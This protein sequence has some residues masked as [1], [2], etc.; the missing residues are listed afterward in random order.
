MVEKCEICNR[1]RRAWEGDDLDEHLVRQHADHGPSVSIQYPERYERLFENGNVATGD[2]E[3]GGGADAAG[4][5]GD[6][7]VAE[8]GTADDGDSGATTSDVGGGG[9]GPPAGGTDRADGPAEGGLDAPTSEGKKWYVIGVGGAG[10]NI[11][12]AILCRRETLLARNDDRA[13]LWQGGLAGYGLLNTN[14]V[15]LERTYYVQEE[16]GWERGADI[17]ENAMIGRGKHNYQGMGRRWDDGREVMQADFEEG[18]PFRTRWD[19]DVRNIRDA[20][21]VLFIHSVTKGTGCGAT[22]VLAEHV[23]E[24][25]LTGDHIVDKPLLSAVVLPSPD[26]PEGGSP[27]GSRPK[28]NGVV[29]MARTSRA[30]DAIIPFDNDCL[31]S[32]SNSI[33]VDI[34]GIEQYNSTYADHNRSLVAFLEAFTLSST[35]QFVDHDATLDIQGEVFDVADSFRTVTDLY[36]NIRDREYTPAVVLAPALGSVRPPVD[37]DTLD[38]LLRNTLHQNPLADFDPSSSW[39]GTFLLFG[40]EE[41][42]R[43]V[44]DLVRQNTFEDLVS[45]PDFLDAESYDG[46]GSLDMH[47]EQLIVPYVD[48]VYLWG[49]LWNPKM[50]S[51]HR[52]YEHAAEL[53]KD[54]SSERAENV[55]E[56]WDLIEPLFSCLGRENMG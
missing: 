25:V 50:P 52:M 13:P 4:D 26:D 49:T 16:K 27:F 8:S 55:R 15:E 11:V 33:G 7:P 56:S 40:P 3:R 24:D 51:L 21:A 5:E 20:Q 46:P 6:G 38:I 9:D 1:S 36:S 45:G 53:K 39:G 43:Q 22:P 32:A 10:N 54:G 37:E 48:D 12:D 17:V 47:V 14:L 35:P 19:M 31:E 23:R 34:E 41:G 42:M 44:S 2:E 18:D 30:V 29:G 28:T